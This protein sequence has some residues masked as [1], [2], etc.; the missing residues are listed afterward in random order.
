MIL[1]YK[2]VRIIE[3]ERIIIEK[4]NY[5]S[6]L[7]T[8][9]ILMLIAILLITLGVKAQENQLYIG[10]LITEYL[11]IMLP[12]ITYIKLRGYSI[13]ETLKLNSIGLR[14]II[15]SILIIL[16]SYPVAVFFNYIGFIILHYIGEIKPSPIP[17]PSTYREFLISFFIFALSPGIC[18]EIMFRGFVLNAYKSLGKK[19]TII[20]SGI[21]FGL[22]HFNLQ[23][24]LGPI[25]LG[26]I[27]GMIYIKT[28]SLYSSIIGHAVNNT[29]ALAIGAYFNLGEDN[30]NLNMEEINMIG[31]SEL[32]LSL[33]ILGITAIIFGVLSYR[34]LKLLDNK[35][36][37]NL[38][39][40]NNFLPDEQVI[41]ELHQKNTLNIYEIIP[42]LVVLMCFIKINYL[43]FFL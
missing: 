22:F 5:P 34:L 20:Y 13:K 8:N 23:N 1:V 37:M 11:I 38:N 25:Y 26:I 15:I 40:R 21:L 31:T 41:L 30:Y 42:I 29:I 18:E 19:K 24:L 27:L 3:K 39:E 12:I 14:E 4:S 17:I 6:I 35:S 7:E 36:N 28:N 33:F 16:S 10:L 2:K 9:I 43:Y 32:L